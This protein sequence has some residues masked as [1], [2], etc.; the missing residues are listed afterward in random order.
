MISTKKANMPYISWVRCF[1]RHL[2]LDFDLSF[3]L[4]TNA[5]CV[6]VHP[7]LPSGSIFRSF[8]RVYRL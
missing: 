2:L 7:Q 8:Y 1:P 5:L 6:Q 4:R 3:K